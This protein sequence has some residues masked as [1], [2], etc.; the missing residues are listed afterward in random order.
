MYKC[1]H[2][3]TLQELKLY[4]IGIDSVSSAD[5]T[6][7]ECTCKSSEQLKAKVPVEEITGI[8]HYYNCKVQLIVL[9]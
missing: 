4:V 8:L 6:Y 9:C 3:L 1:L 7:V 5:C 2:Y